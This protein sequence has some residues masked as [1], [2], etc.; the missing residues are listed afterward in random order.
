MAP[1]SRLAAIVGASSTPPRR[2]ET[3]SDGQSFLVEKKNAFLVSLVEESLRNGM[4]WLWIA[5]YLSSLVGTASDFGSGVIKWLQGDLRS[6]LLQTHDVCL[7]WSLCFLNTSPL[8]CHQSQ[9]YPEKIWPPQPTCLT[10]LE[11]YLPYGNPKQLEAD[12][13]NFIHKSRSPTIHITK[14]KMSF[15]Q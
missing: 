9:N 12:N 14:K 15:L 2:E 8:G 10:S 4:K 13:P 1:R 6:F 7:C 5:A 3:V 11:V